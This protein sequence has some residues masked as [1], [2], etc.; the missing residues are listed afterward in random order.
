[1]ASWGKPAAQ[2]N[3]EGS[4]AY[5]LLNDF[6]DHKHM[7]LRARQELQQSMR[8]AHLR[9]LH[10][11][12]CATGFT[13]A[14][15]AKDA[16][17]SCFASLGTCQH[18]VVYTCHAA[19]SAQWVD[20]L[21]RGC[22]TQRRHPAK[23]AVAVPRPATK[24]GVLS[25]GPANAARRPHSQIL[26]ECDHYAREQFGGAPAHDTAA[27]RKQDQMLFEFGR[28]RLEEMQAQAAEQ[29]RMKR[30]PLHQPTAT[31]IREGMIKQVCRS[32]VDDT[33]CKCTAA[34]TAWRVMC[35][36]LLLAQL[37]PCTQAIQ[38]K[39]TEVGTLQIFAE[40]E[41][42]ATFLD[43]L[44]GAKVHGDTVDGVKLEI[45]NRLNELEA[46]GIATDRQQRLPAKTESPVVPLQ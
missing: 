30:V 36:S 38:T 34:A 14:E 8:G 27:Q 20:T 26:A 5:D 3:L 23:S 4:A 41:E 39:S 2:Q 18:E 16:H 35:V 31:E 42:R 33:P 12:G 25:L 11:K 7:S 15:T 21:S 9:M 45:V 40:I 6:M 37:R 44:Q 32:N 1:M 17:V 13:T 22:A 24:P 29:Q 19:G 46:Y 28:R 43:S 10:V